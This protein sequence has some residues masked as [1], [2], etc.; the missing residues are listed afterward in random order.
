MC[1]SVRTFYL[2]SSQ[3]Q[4]I[5]INVVDAAAAADDDG[6]DFCEQVESFVYLLPFAQ[7]LYPQ[8]Y[9]VPQDPHH[10]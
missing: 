1:L 3:S 4:P 5:V 7:G 6:S 2:W 10:R 8:V 9:V